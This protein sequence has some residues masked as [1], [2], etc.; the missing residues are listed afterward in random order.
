MPLMGFGTFKVTGGETIGSVVDAALKVGYR[1]FDTAQVYQ[2]EA[3]LG[4]AFE[5]LLPKYGLTRADIFITSKLQPMDY[6]DAVKATKESLSKLRTEYLDLMLVHYPKSFF[7]GTDD[8]PQNPQRRK[9]TWLAYELL[10]AGGKLRSIGV[11][12]YEIKHMEEMNTYANVKPMVNQ[13][14][15]HPHFT[16]AALFDYCK[17]NGIHLQAHTSLARNN[18]DLIGEPVLKKIAAKHNATEQQVLF[19]WA[20]YQNVSVLPKSVS[21]ERM[22]SNFK[23]TELQLDAG[24]ILEITSLNRDKFYTLAN[25]WK[26]N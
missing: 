24:E 10:L 2:N 18:P 20:M 5:T 23:A 1:F 25:A 6:E 13:M 8:D 22:A 19:A 3:E 7:S 11:S 15:F 26:V 9:D 16:R 4:E 17:A 12:N 14:E 21:P